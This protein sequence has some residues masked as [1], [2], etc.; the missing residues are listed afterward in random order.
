[1]L[2]SPADRTS[3]SH[4]LNPTPGPSRQAI[5]VSYLAESNGADDQSSATESDPDPSPIGFIL[6]VIGDLWPVWLLLLIAFLLEHFRI[7][8][9]PLI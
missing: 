3:L 4:Q 2:P 6:T 9:L 7:A 1:M 8:D 5:G